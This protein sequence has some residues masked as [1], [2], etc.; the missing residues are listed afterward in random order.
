MVARGRAREIVFDASEDGAVRTLAGGTSGRDAALFDAIPARQSTRSGYDGST[1][2][3]ADPTKL[4]AAAALPG[5]DLVQVTA[6]FQMVN[7]LDLIVAANSAQIADP[8]FVAELKQWLRFSQHAVMMAGD[9][10]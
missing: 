10:L 8:S 5:V 4:A 2:N 3:P 7:L 6:L 1:V 9:V